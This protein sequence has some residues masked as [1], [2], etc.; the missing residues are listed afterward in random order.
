MRRADRT[1]LARCLLDD[2]DQFIQIL[3][4]YP[5]R[6]QATLPARPVAPGNQPW[7]AS[8]GPAPD[9]KPAR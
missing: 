6:R 9:W 2:C 7:R 3:W 5:R 4:R 1:N 8:T